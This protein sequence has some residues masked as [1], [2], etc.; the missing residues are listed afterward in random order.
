MAARDRRA[1]AAPA[2]R[3]LALG[4]ALAAL[5]AGVVVFLLVRPRPARTPAVLDPAGAGA[6]TGTSAP[7]RPGLRA[8]GLEPVVP[9]GVS[10]EEERAEFNRVMAESYRQNVRGVQH[11]IDFPLWSRPLTDEDRWRP[12]TP[13][14]QEQRGPRSEHHVLH[15]WPAKLSFHA[16][17]P[18]VVYATVTVRGKA[19][20]PTTIEGW[21][22]SAGHRNRPDAPIRFRDDGG[23]PDQR[24]GDFL[25]TAE[26]EL[27]A[28]TRRRHAGDWG[29]RVR[30][31]L[32]DEPIETMNM[33]HLWPTDVVLTGRY[34]DAVED[35]SLVVYVGVRAREARELWQ[36]R[37]ELHGPRGEEIGFAWGNQPVPAGE[38][39]MR[40]AFWGKVIHDRGVDGPYRLVH[41]TMV[42]PIGD[43][44]APEATGI[45]HVTNPYRAAQF[46]ADAFHADD[47]MLND[48]LAGYRALAERA[49][50]GELPLPDEPAVAV[51][52]GR[53]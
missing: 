35:G 21:L 4:L 40:L 47:P 14:L 29:F 52:T 50:R 45:A 20:A 6:A 32:G 11:K 46:R 49:E 3:R 34:R 5:A 31:T 38:S 48:K 2:R 10:A 26:I 13:H 8:D 24:R 1:G 15:I 28:A 53:P 9:E 7:A 30:I 39:E 12:P 19:V 17:E 33:F 51:P 36:V 25:Y 44:R 37:A 18:I 41:V 23:G 42:D 22:D 16:D 43:M 27:D